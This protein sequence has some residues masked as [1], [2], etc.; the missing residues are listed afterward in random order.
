MSHGLSLMI[1]G[2]KNF[3]VNMKTP[4]EPLLRVLVRFPQP[5]LSA[6]LETVNI[7]TS[8]QLRNLLHAAVKPTLKENE[9]SYDETFR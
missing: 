2:S 4:V 1:S 9:S 5:D 7:C 6:A 3:L 8:V